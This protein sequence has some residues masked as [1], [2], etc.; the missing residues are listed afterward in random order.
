[1][2]R[3][4]SALA[5]VGAGLGTVTACGD[6]SQAVSLRDTETSTQRSGA[7][8]GGTSAIADDARRIG[9]TARSFRFVPAQITVTAEEDIAI[10]LTSEDSL[11][12]FKIDE[13]SAHVV[14]ETGQTAV[15]GCRT[16]QPG[17][18]TFYCSV[19]GHR[20]AGMEGVVVVE[21]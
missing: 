20:D 6:D 8:V 11:H 2:R 9:V 18:Y 10:V 7:H 3:G 13:L 16:D 21:A 4:I 1:M 14:A 19:A 12:D 17:R 5:A 15:G